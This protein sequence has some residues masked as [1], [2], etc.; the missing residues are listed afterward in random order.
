MQSS[1]DQTGYC[2]MDRN[3][4]P[5][6]GPVLPVDDAASVAES[7]EAALDDDRSVPLV[8]SVLGSL[9]LLHRPGWHDKGDLPTARLFAHLTIL[10][11]I[12]APRQN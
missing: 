6:I 7:A 8:G 2:G 11:L 10:A 1:A 5:A 4:G 9:N 3:T 12:W